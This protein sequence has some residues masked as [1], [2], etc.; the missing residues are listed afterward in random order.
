MKGSLL[1]HLLVLPKLDRHSGLGVPT[2]IQTKC[3]DTNKSNRITL[4]NT[5]IDFRAIQ[6]YFNN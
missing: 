2:I 3:L 5:S 4:D 1:V 6:L